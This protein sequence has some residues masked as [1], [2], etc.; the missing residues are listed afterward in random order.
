MHDLEPTVVS[1]GSVDKIQTS[2]SGDADDLR[3][4]LV[5]VGCH[6]GVALRHARRIHHGFDAFAVAVVTATSGLERGPNG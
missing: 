4:V 6:E 2:Q 1:N 3:F 5:I